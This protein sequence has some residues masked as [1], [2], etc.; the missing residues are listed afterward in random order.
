MSVEK[1]FAIHFPSFSTTFLQCVSVY[2]C[3]R[4]FYINF[5]ECRTFPYCFEC[6]FG[7]QHFVDDTRVKEE[8]WMKVA[9][10]TLPIY[11]T[12]SYT[13]I[14]G[15]SETQP[16][17][18]VILFCYK[19]KQKQKYRKTHENFSSL[20]KGKPEVKSKKTLLSFLYQ[21][22]RVCWK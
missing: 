2:V 9:A 18:P 7:I 15:C 3:D 12:K 16:T 1:L 11:I 14:V 5:I 4:K 22:K 13:N 19:I 20:L 8:K 10:W 6:L 21:I 17:L